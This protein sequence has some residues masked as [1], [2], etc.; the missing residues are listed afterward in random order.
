MGSLQCC[1]FV[2]SVRPSSDGACHP[3]TVM[4]MSPLT[5]CPPTRRVCISASNWAP[6][7][8]QFQRDRSFALD[9]HCKHH[10]A[11]SA[12]K[13][14]RASILFRTHMR[15]SSFS[16]SNKSCSCL[17][18]SF[19]SISPDTFSLD[20]PVRLTKNWRSCG[21]ADPRVR[22]IHVGLSHGAVLIIVGARCGGG[23]GGGGRGESGE[24]ARVRLVIVLYITCRVNGAN[25]TRARGF[26]QHL[27][28]TSQSYKRAVVVSCDAAALAQRGET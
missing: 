24:C 12:P 22:M 9:V 6:V 16:S 13:Q 7:S 2:S 1:H 26:R 10:F 21:W 23:R 25:Q 3:S 20:S 15:P 8:R 19:S 5:T 28:E 4:I 17:F 14:P 18:V 11:S 27:C